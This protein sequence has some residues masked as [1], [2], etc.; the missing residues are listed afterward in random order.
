VITLPSADI[1]AGPDRFFD[2][3]VGCAVALAV[4]QLLFVRHPVNLVATALERTL[5]RLAAGLREAGVALEQDSLEL[6]VAALA[7][8]RAL[9]SEIA[10]LFEAL[11][12]AREAASILP[13]RR[14][15]RDQLDPLV[16]AARQIDYAVRNSRVLIR[17]VASALR[18]RVA[19]APELAAA[20]ATLAAAVDALS[21]QLVSAG[22][23][24]RTRSAAVAAADQATTVL[25]L[26]HDLRTTMII[27]QIRATAVDLLRATGL[28]AGRSRAAIPPAP[29]DAFA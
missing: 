27:G 12:M 26:H 6:A 16:D 19:V 2:A 7:D 15:A 22:D 8:L 3:L 24:M 10:S 4:S 14:R 25:A 11:G 28:D 9:D 21:D 5:G 13:T 23:P 20:L 17:A 18:T 29:A 1:S